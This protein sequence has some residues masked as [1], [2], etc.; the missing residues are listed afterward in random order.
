MTGINH[1]NLTKEQLKKWGCK[2]TTLRVGD[3]PNYDLW[4]DDKA[5]WSEDYFNDVK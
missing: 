3:K 4:I 1:F 5:V 2:Y